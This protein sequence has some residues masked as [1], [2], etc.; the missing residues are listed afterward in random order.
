[1]RAPA[2]RIEDEVEETTGAPRPFLVTGRSIVDAVLRSWG[3][4]VTAGLVGA[5]LGAVTVLAL[6]NPSDATTTLLM[7]HPDTTDESAMTTDVSLLQTRSVATRAVAELGVDQSPESFLSAVTVTPVNTQILELTVEAP[8]DAEAVARATALIDAFLEF[9]AQQLRSISDGLVT[10]YQKRIEDLQGQ[11]ADLTREYDALSADP[12]A[13]DARASDILTAR[14]TL[15]SQI[16]TMQRSI[17]DAQLKTESAITAT[18]VI[19]E[20]ATS[21]H[22]VRRQM[23][24]A[25]GSG[26]VLGVGLVIAFILFRTLTSDVVRVRR[27]VSAALG[28]PVRVGV[29]PVPSQRFLPRTLAA[30]RAQIATLLRGWPHRWTS[31]Y[32]DRPLELLV[33]GAE[34]AL[35]SHLVAPVSAAPRTTSRR[36]GPTTIG[37]VAIDHTVAAALVLDTLGRR[38][39]ERGASVLLVDLSASGALSAVTVDDDE[40]ADGPVPQRFRPDGDPALATGPRR[41]ARASTPGKDALG[42][43]G[44]LWSEA[45]VALVLIEVDPGTDLSI[46]RTW[47]NRVIPLV[48][49]G[50]ASAELLGT[51]S[52]L[53]KDAGLDLPFALVEGAERS[54]RTLGRPATGADDGPAPQAV[55]S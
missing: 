1:M 12:N 10:G 51:V 27:E 26:A 37:L 8:D 14:A 19:D 44:E 4:W 35:P 29:G 7:V 30:A 43:L 31:Q 17:E 38:L 32:R 49:A 34:A 53:V 9:R 39:A 5:L 3:A 42:P 50:R 6:P 20:P 18:H 22:G 41:G 15:S 23:L 21:P 25:A 16:T 28:V 13:D 55:Q 48:T 24:L 47:V 45:Q 33:Q 11:V 46:L 54:D 52:T 40:Q 2:W 36:T